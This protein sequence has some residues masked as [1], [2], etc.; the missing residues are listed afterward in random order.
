MGF[1]AFCVLGSLPGL[2]THVL[3]LG[4]STLTLGQTNAK[5]G[6]RNGKDSVKTLSR[7][8]GCEGLEWQAP[9][10]RPQYEAG[11]RPTYKGKDFWRNTV[12]ASRGS[13]ARVLLYSPVPRLL[14]C[15][16]ADELGEVRRVLST[17]SASR[18]YRARLFVLKPGAPISRSK[19]LMSSIGTPTRCPCDACDEQ[20]CAVRSVVCRLCSR[21]PSSVRPWLFR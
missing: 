8:E 19:F 20:K 3:N 15:C 10:W 5:F 12:R 2:T 1:L 18:R 17:T 13:A 6:Q 4:L 9:V 14:W 11:P 21:H 16:P 7:A